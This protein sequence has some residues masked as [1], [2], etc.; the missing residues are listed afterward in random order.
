MVKWD[1][2]K[3]IP[4]IHVFADWTTSSKIQ[5]YDNHSKLNMQHNLEN[6]HD[7]LL[8]TRIFAVIKGKI[9]M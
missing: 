9:F 2:K 6:P 8:S 5:K 7:Y 1:L 3:W 4:K